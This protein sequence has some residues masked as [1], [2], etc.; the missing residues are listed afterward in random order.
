VISS[1]GIVDQQKKR[2]RKHVL[3]LHWLIRCILLAV[4]SAFGSPEKGVAR[5]LPSL[6]SRACWW[7]KMMLNC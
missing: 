1:G 6:R 3:L 2:C 7:W 5:C 4:T